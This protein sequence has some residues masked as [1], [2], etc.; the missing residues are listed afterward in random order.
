MAKEEWQFW[1][2]VEKDGGNIRTIEKATS[3][4]MAETLLMANWAPELKI[5]YEVK[6]LVV[7]VAS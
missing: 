5:L 3:K 4:V 6:P 7:T 1:G 2:A